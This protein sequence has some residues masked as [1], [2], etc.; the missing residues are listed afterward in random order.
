MGEKY[1][2]SIQVIEEHTIY[3]MLG[4]GFNPTPTGDTVSVVSIQ[5]LMLNKLNDIYGLHISKDIL[6]KIVGLSASGLSVFEISKYVTAGLSIPTQVVSTAILT[7]AMGRAYLE[8]I[9]KGSDLTAEAIASVI[10]SYLQEGASFVISEG[11]VRAVKKA[12]EKFWEVTEN[13]AQLLGEF[14][15]KSI[16]VVGGSI[17]FVGEILG[18]TVDAVT[19]VAGQALNKGG[20][21]VGDGADAVTDVAGQALDKGGEI[22]DEAIEGLKKLNPF[23]W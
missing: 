23:K 6:V 13:T 5:S 3:S 7:Y 19:D 14:T 8:V 17:V 18:D 16:E 2:K 12:G 10:P 22:V 15:G 11:S 21:V 9:N 20:Q 4:V 1:S